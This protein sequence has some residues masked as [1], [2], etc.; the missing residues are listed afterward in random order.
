MESRSTLL[1]CGLHVEGDD[2]DL[3][4]RVVKRGVD[5]NFA[6]VRQILEANG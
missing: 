1:G 3:G 6:A 2:F 5:A 4:A